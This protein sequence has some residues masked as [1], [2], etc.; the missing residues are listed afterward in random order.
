MSRFALPFLLAMGVSQPVMASTEEFEK[1]IIAALHLSEFQTMPAE[2]RKQLAE[3]SLAYWKNFDSRIPRNSPA[4]TAWLRRELDTTDTM[5]INRAV[6]S[7]AYA[8]EQLGALSTNCISI[9]ESLLNA[10]GGAKATEL[11]L[12]L[13]STQCYSNTGTAHY[14]LL[15]GLSNG[16]Y[17]GAFKMQSFTMVLSTITG[18]LA[19]SIIQE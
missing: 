15:A 9:F 17:D 10:V 3:T 5:R 4:D 7:P 1:A 11:Y 6:N 8:H 18:K 13:K 2:Q 14:Q 19:N 16:R 12:W